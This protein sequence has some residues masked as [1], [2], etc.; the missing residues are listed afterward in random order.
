MTGYVSKPFKTE[1]LYKAI[2]DSMRSEN[3]KRIITNEYIDALANI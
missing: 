2:V 1:N 3:E